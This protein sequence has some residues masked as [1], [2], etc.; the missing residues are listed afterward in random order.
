M[1]DFQFIVVNSIT[2]YMI[3]EIRI[4]SNSMNHRKFTSVFGISLNRPKVCRAIYE[5]NIILG[6]TVTANMAVR[7]T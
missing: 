4:C 2:Q 1:N 6:D 5:A 7:K 3:T